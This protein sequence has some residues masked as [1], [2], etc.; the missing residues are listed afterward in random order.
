MTPRG[1]AS[2][3]TLRVAQRGLSLIETLVA[4]GILSFITLGIA[5]LL[6]ISISQNNLAQHRSTATGLAEERLDM[7]TSMAFQPAADFANYALPGE[8]VEAGPPRTLTADFGAIPDFPR[9]RRVVTLT[10][11]TP[12]TSMLHVSCE[13]FWQDPRQGQKRHV[14]HAYLHPTLERLP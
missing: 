2:P 13:V 12:V 4:L 11:D 7:L 14:L 6:G 10:Y 5:S 8:V 1:P 3:P 9:F